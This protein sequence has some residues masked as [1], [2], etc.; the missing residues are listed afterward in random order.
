MAKNEEIDEVRYEEKK[1]QEQIATT[2]RMS[3]IPVFVAELSS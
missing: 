1:I 2:M 3:F